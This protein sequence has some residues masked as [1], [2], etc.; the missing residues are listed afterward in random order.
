MSFKKG[1]I[2]RH[3]V[4][5]KFFE[6][7]SAHGSKVLAREVNSQFENSPLPDAI[8]DINDLELVLDEANAAFNILF[9]DK[10]EE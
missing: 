7:Q 8:I 1:Q 10:D 2:V 5:A 4:L 3:K 9:E 6:V